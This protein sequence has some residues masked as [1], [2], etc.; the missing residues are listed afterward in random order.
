MPNPLDFTITDPDAMRYELMRDATMKDGGQ[1]QHQDMQRVHMADGGMFT[2]LI[3]GSP[4]KIKPEVGRFIDTTTEQAY[5]LKRAADKMDVYG[6]Q[7]P[8]YLNQFDVPSEKLIR[9]DT[10]FTPDQITQMRKTWSKI[11]ADTTSLMGE[12]LYDLATQHG[13]GHDTLMPHIA[14]SIDYA[15]YQRLPTGTGGKDEWFRIT[16]PDYLQRVRNEAHGG[17]VHMADGGQAEMPYGGVSL[18]NLPERNAFSLNSKPASQAYSGYDVPQIDAS[19]KPM[20]LPK[21]SYDM[22]LDMINNDLAKG[23]KPDWMSFEDFAQDQVSRG[24]GTG[25]ILPAVMKAMSFPYEMAEKAIGS[26]MGIDPMMGMVGKMGELHAIPGAARYMASRLAPELKD[27]AAMAADLYMQGRMPGMVAPASY[28]ILP[29]KAALRMQA[30]SIIDPQRMAFPGIYGNPAEIAAEAASRVAPESENLKKVFG[31]TRDDLYEIGKELRGNLPG[32][33]PGAAA[34][35]KGSAAAEKIMTNKNVQRI[36]DVNA[37]AEKYPELV[38][39]MD[40]WY[41]MTPYYKRMEE[42]LGPKKAAIEYRLQNTL[43]GMASPGSE[44]TTEIPR[45]SAA[46]FLHKQG[47]WPEFME[48]LAVPA[49]KREAAGVASDI[50]DVPGHVYHRTAQAKPMDT[51]LRT[52]EMDMSSPKV[53]MYIEASGVPQT[54]F[55]TQTPVGDAHWSRAVGL[56]DA[57][58]K[59]MRK[60][61]EI[62][63]GASVSNPEMTQLAPWWRDKIAAELGIESVPAQA[64]TWGAFSGQTGVTTPIGSPKLEMIADQIAMTAKRL[65]VSL[66]TAR[67]MVM[68]GQARIGK[69]EGGEVSIDQMRHELTKAK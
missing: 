21:T 43:M 8:G 12:D 64:R 11:P 42:L 40:P 28:A 9:F 20:A 35:P 36:L 45:G 1:V 61:V 24:R 66:E 15:G 30:K 25:H 57:R 47:R 5:A 26:S 29:E 62:V 4:T 51:F 16:N 18:D 37:E 2:R 32:T 14:K 41:V 44:V 31:V 52:G 55:Q 69:K 46:Y 54:G 17:A 56:A 3:H 34:N 68:L 6:Q 49:N 65:G 39:N 13:V 58:N 59:Q 63:P 60:G 23:I 27:T 33:L 67:D 19:G 22:K 7:G 10:Q 48:S 50:I 53:P 38:R